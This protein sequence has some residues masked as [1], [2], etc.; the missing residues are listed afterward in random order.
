[1]LILIQLLGKHLEKE[2][3]ESVKEQ[4]RL[5]LLQ[6]LTQSVLVKELKRLRDE[7]EVAIIIPVFQPP[8][9]AS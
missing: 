9:S 4:I 3:T 8:K 1:M 7:A 6:Q 2:N 5:R